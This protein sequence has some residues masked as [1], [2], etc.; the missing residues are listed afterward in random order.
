MYL[1]QI[2]NFMKYC[3]YISDP[4]RIIHAPS[5]KKL[6]LSINLLLG[7]GKIQILSF[8]VNKQTKN[9]QEKDATHELILNLNP[10]YIH[11]ASIYFTGPY[12]HTPLN[13]D[14]SLPTL[15]L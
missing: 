2:L 13:T 11:S 7:E 5:A 4:I 3:L 1:N 8:N 14:I 6:A 10:E 9:K 15:A 12:F